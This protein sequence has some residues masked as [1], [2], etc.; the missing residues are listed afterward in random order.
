MRVVYNFR[1]DNIILKGC[2]PRKLLQNF[3]SVVQ[4]QQ[5]RPL[6]AAAHECTFFTRPVTWCNQ[7]IPCER[8]LISAGEQ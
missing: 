6:Y 3:V 8:H 5:E 4:Y 2:T 1:V 7:G